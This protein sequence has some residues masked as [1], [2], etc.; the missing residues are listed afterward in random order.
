MGQRRERRRGRETL[1]QSSHFGFQLKDPAGGWQG[2]G[3]VFSKRWQFLPSLGSRINQK[4]GV[5]VFLRC[6]TV[7]QTM[8]PLTVLQPVSRCC[9]RAETL[10]PRLKDSEHPLNTLES[11]TFPYSL[12]VYILCI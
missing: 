12:R 11:Q 4:G 6:R 9:L 8:R 3:R 2:P 5:R 1:R 7:R 10:P